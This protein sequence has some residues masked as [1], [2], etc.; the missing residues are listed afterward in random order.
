MALR[1]SINQ[2]VH[3]TVWNTN[4]MLFIIIIAVNVLEKKKK[5]KNIVKTGNHFF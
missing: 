1:N 2:I 4:V 5:K 3:N